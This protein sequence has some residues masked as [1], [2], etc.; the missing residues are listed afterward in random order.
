MPESQRRG[1]S[2]T[3]RLTWLEWALLLSAAQACKLDTSKFA[4]RAI[5]SAARKRANQRY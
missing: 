4:R 1:R 2:L 3:L 5:L